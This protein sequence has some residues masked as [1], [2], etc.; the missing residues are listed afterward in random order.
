M[1]EVGVTWAL[2]KLFAAIVIVTPE[3]ILSTKVVSSASS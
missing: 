2:T 3:S 1:A